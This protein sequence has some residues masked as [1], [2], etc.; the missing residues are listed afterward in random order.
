M[1]QLA[2]HYLRHR[3]RSFAVSFLAIWLGATLL[4]SFL[5]L[6]DTV[7]ADDLDSEAVES[8]SIMG[9]VV[10]SWSLVIVVFALAST[11]TLVVRQRDGEM[12]LLK[13]VGATPGQIRRLIV[14][15]T[16][17][18][19]V[20]ATLAA[21]VPGMLA[22]NGVLTLMQDTGQV[23]DGVVHDFGPIALGVGTAATLLAAVVAAATAA[24]RTTTISVQDATVAAAIGTA[25]LGKARIV[26]GVV[27]LVLGVNAGV[28]T[29][30]VFSD[31]DLEKMGIAG[32]SVVFTSIGFALL[33]PALVRM[34]IAV[35]A[36]PVERFAG[37]SG[38]LT[39]LNLRQRTEQLAG[40]LVPIILFTGIAAGT[41]YLQ[42]VENSAVAASGI[43]KTTEAKN[44]EM[45]NMVVVSMIAL[46]AAIMLV[47]TLIAATVHRRRE[48]AQHRLAGSTPP[49]VLSMVSVESVVLTLTGVVFGTL[50]A[51]PG[52]IAYSLARSDTL[53]PDASAGIY[54]GVVGVAAMLAITSTVGA[55]RQVIRTPAVHSLA[56]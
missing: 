24:R 25:R 18:V 35:L 28:L 9:F 13:S 7:A 4:M 2:M 55:A 52:V 30:T 19:A 36:K 26:G 1:F 16:A 42:G 11:L 49:Q 8:L 41:L 46:F 10:S 3:T 44:I 23:P 31:L 21:I 51:A 6:L 27:L 14:F 15:E 17:S 43:A 45:G 33:A 38:Y 34:S 53:A 54:L 56:A 48:F 39:I 22:G 29:A 12:A 40:A 32:Q 20:V 5:S 50:A 47:N 37:L